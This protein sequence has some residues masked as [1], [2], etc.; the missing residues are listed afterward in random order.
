MAVLE[1]WVERPGPR[2][3]AKIPSIA[4]FAFAGVVLIQVLLIASHVPWGDEL[5]ALMISREPFGRMFGLL[6][7]IAASPRGGAAGR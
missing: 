6:E 3:A 2:R 5:Q 7:E 4:T 1:N